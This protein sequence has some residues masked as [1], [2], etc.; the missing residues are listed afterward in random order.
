MS[1]IVSIVAMSSSGHFEEV[2]REE[3]RLLRG[4]SAGAERMLGYKRMNIGRKR[5]RTTNPWPRLCALW[6]S[7]YGDTPVQCRELL[8]RPELASALGPLCEGR[9]PTRRLGWLLRQKKGQVVGRFRIESRPGRHG[10][11]VH[12]LVPARPRRHWGEGAGEN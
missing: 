8:Q 6:W 9:S 3:Q 10:G 2:L 5:P 12:Y 11:R 1:R 7:A 4:E